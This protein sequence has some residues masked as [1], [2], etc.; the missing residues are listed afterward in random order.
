MAKRINKKISDVDGSDGKGPNRRE[1]RQILK[2][3][4]K[5][6]G[7]PGPRGAYKM[8]GPGILN[9]KD[10]VRNAEE[11]ANKALESI[12]NSKENP[13]E[14]SVSKAEEESKIAIQASKDAE[15][16]AD[17]VIQYEKSSNKEQRQSRR[18]YKRNIQFPEGETS[19]SLKSDRKAGREER[20]AGREEGRDARFNERQARRDEKNNITEEDK[21]KIGEKITSAINSVKSAFTGGGVA[22]AESGK[23]ISV[24]PVA[25][26]INKSEEDVQGLAQQNNNSL[27]TSG[28]DLVN[29]AASSDKT[30]FEEDNKIVQDA[31]VADQKEQEVKN[32]VVNNTIQAVDNVETAPINT[33]GVTETEILA[34]DGKTVV[35]AQGPAV[36]G[37][38]SYTSTA[39]KKDILDGVINN[40]YA[41]LNDTP[42]LV[43][44]KLQPYDYYPN[45]SKDINVGTYSGKYLG[46]VSLF[47]APGARLPM[48]LYDARKR[49]L[50]EQAKAKQAEIE[51]LLTIPETDPLYQAQFSEMFLDGALGFLQKHKFNVTALKRDPEALKFFAQY[52]AKSKEIMAATKFADSVIDKSQDLKNYIPKS[53]RN[54][55]Y[56]VK[57]NLLEK[58]PDILEGK[59]SAIR[60][61]QNAKVYS[62]LV[63]EVDKLAK[64]LLN[65]ERMSQ[66]PLQL[67]G[68]DEAKAEAMRKGEKF[69]AAKYEE[70]KNN[71]IAAVNDGNYNT[72]TYVTGIRKFFG[73]DYEA[74]IDNLIAATPNSNEEQAEALKEY[75]ASQIQPQEILKYTTAQNA[76]QWQ[77]QLAERRRQFDLER[78]DKINNYWGGVNEAMNDKI[79]SQTGKSFNQEL[80]EL[81][82]KGLTGAALETELKR[83]SRTYHVGTDAYYNPAT[84]GFASF[85][86]ASPELR[87]QNAELQ[88]TS[89]GTKAV[90]VFTVKVGS[91]GETKRVS[92][93]QMGA[94][95]QKNSK[96]DSKGNPISV[97]VFDVSTGKRFKPEDVT[98]YKA[99]KAG[100]LWVKPEGF[101]ERKAFINGN[102]FLEY[103]KADGSNLARYNASKAKKTYAVPIERAFN[104]VSYF[105]AET[106]MNEYRDV[107]LS[108]NVYGEA[109]DISTPA[110]QAILNNKTGYGIGKA[111]EATRIGETTWDSGSGSGSSSSSPVISTEP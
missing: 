103:L 68:V 88:R 49:A 105:N 101:E 39:T 80:A 23:S 82:T 17:Q 29:A 94:F 21:P 4:I 100:S 26:A 34:G 48:G 99:Q 42:G 8:Y 46:S 108:G 28:M 13:S 106:N 72:D 85:I 91:N 107:E 27:P 92:A 96:L 40:A 81:Q 90:K 74:M 12:K 50:V 38:P 76:N 16:S 93:D 19:D 30:T 43:L 102:G 98:G 51:K 22:N 25:N 78:E 60:P 47:A 5:E 87:K 36:G 59:E 95:L 70:D 109:I 62:S 77:A 18:E 65:P 7:M 84:G 79:N 20:R 6:S 66:A 110:G 41:D 11:K 32:D 89:D 10:K 67:K 56:D 73:G 1:R 53:M 14:E 24:S 104:R 35:K 57:M 44:E 58:T 33:G 52:Q 64:D 15:Q 45:I 31:N 54:T 3:Q 97:N 69:D 83:I 111:A 61:I 75:F 37:V 55:A 71:F 9:L 63:P 86:Q 2:K